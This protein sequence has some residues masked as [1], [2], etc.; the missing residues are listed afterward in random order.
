VNY[1]ANSQVTRIWILWNAQDGFFSPRRR[2]TNARTVD[3]EAA[4]EHIE[5]IYPAIKTP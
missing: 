2:N 5:V 4:R 1:K 3:Q